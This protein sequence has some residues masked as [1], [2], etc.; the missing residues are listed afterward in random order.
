MC[1]FEINIFELWTEFFV[2]FGKKYYVLF[3]QFPN[4]NF[5]PCV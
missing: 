2:C 3:L 1:Y 5:S 4:C